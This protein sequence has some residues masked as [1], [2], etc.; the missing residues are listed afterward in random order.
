MTIRE[1]QDP[2]AGES[3]REAHRQPASRRPIFDPTDPRSGEILTVE[4]QERT[5]RPDPPSD[6]ESRP[7]A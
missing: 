2:T 6:P 7:A 3:A 4:G 5:D 1:I